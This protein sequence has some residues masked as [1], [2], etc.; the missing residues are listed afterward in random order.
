MQ[1]TNE[2]E[3][4]GGELI[5]HINDKK[6]IGSKKLGDIT[7][8]DSLISHEVTPVKTGFRRSLVGWIV[9]PRV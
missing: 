6:I 3:Y 9:G 8:F 5:I 1:L 7:F 4:T 2:H